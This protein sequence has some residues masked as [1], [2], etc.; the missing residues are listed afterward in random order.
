MEQEVDIDGE[1]LGE[2]AD[3]LAHLWAVAYD[4]VDSAG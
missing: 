1:G 4:D 2:L 3:G